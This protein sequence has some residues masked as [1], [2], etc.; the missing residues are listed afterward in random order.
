MATAKGGYYTVMV[1]PERAQERKVPYIVFAASDYHAARI[2][3]DRTG[4]LAREHEVEGP[5]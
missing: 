2:V 3:R 4:Y 1:G 5:R